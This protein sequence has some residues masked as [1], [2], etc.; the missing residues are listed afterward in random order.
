MHR[1]R[2]ERIAQN[3]AADLYRTWQILNVDDLDGTQIQWAEAALDKVVAAREESQREADRFMREYRQA[4]IPDMGREDALPPLMTLD[5][6]H[7]PDTLP[8]SLPDRFPSRDVIRR[9]SGL[10]DRGTGEPVQP[11]TASEPD[12]AR[13]AAQLLVTGPGEVKR[14]MPSPP[15]AAMNKAFNAHVGA[16]TRIALDGGRDQVISAVGKDTKARGWARFMEQGACYFC[17][18]LASRGVTY[19]ETSFDASDKRFKG[20][21]PALAD[22]AHSARVHDN[23][24]CTTRPVY[25]DRDELDSEAERALAVWKDAT[26]GFTD[27][28]AINAFRRE[29]ERGNPGKARPNRKAEKKRDREIERMMK[30]P[31][32]EDV[33]KA[34]KLLPGLEASL[35]LLKKKGFD[36]DSMPV[37]WHEAEIARL[38]EVIAREA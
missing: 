21:S 2:Q 36:N 35:A 6:Q 28:D 19:K 16:A 34:R 15:D 18:I 13:I 32:V 1:K 26:P 11:L 22:E 17:A 3:L 12:K 29:W 24:Q 37:K 31:A 33:D 5:E 38:S 25:T 20:N 8:Q 10:V 7:D 14:L 4:L 30:D 23:C 9:G 27:R